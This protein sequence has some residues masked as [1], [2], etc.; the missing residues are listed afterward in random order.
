MKINTLIKVKGKIATVCYH[1]L[2]G[3]GAVW[4]THI[5]KKRF[6]DLDPGEELVEPEFML[7]DIKYTI[8]NTGEQ[9]I[10]ERINA[11]CQESLSPANYERWVKVMAGLTLARADLVHIKTSK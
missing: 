11:M 10:L 7:T 6:D 8:I 2:D 5:F 4:G 9:Q 1:N 3:Y